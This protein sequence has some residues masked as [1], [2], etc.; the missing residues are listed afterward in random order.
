DTR[1][2]YVFVPLTVAFR[3]RPRLTLIATAVSVLAFVLEPVLD[4][5]PDR[6]G[7][8]VGYVAVWAG[9]LAWVGVS[10]T[11]LSAIIARR[12]DEV[13]QLV[14]DREQLLTEVLAAEHRER[15]ALAEGLHDGPVQS[16]LATRHDLE[17]VAVKLPEDEALTRAD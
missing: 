15:Q 2:G 4:I 12:T 10:A 6:P 1:I 3:Y 11:V 7:D 9:L 13:M 14:G 17:E 5:G 16:L 8:T